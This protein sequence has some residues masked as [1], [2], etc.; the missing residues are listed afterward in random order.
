MWKTVETASASDTVTCEE[1]Y[2]SNKEYDSFNDMNLADNL[3][4]GIYAYGFENPSILQAR[5]II[6]MIMGRDTVTQAPAGIGKTA[7]LVIAILQNIDISV[8][9]VQALILVPTRELAL[10]TQAVVLSIGKYVGLCCHNCIGRRREDIQKFQNKTAHVVVGTPGCVQDMIQCC[11]LETASIKLFCVDE[12]DD[13]IYRGITK[14]IHDV[15]KFMAPTCQVCLFSATIP[16]DVYEMTEML[17]RDPLRIRVEPDRLTLQRAVQFYVNIEREEWK[18]E[19]LFDIYEVLSISHSIVY[20]NTKY[21]VEWL[22]EKMR[23]RRFDVHMLHGD[24]GLNDRDEN[25]SEFRSGS[26]RVLVAT[27]H[28]FHDID[29]EYVRLIINFDLPSNRENYIRRTGRSSKSNHKVVVINFLTNADM[30]MLRDIEQFYNTCI[31]EM[32]MDI[33]DMF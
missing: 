26:N 11:A 33:A 17:M 22:V 9:A 4:R 10:A 3:L 31:E 8:R 14:R 18:L 28:L 15:F 6:P 16:N 23:K 24:M 25:L 20:I 2:S 7:A 30:N 13:M 12:A 21:K 27:D 5:V 19:T 32:P 29:L 1:V